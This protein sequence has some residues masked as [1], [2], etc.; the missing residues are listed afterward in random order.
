MAGP[1]ALPVHLWSHSFACPSLSPCPTSGELGAYRDISGDLGSSRRSAAR[2]RGRR[3]RR[4][5]W[6]A[7]CRRPVHSAARV[8]RRRSQLAVAWATLPP[9]HAPA[10]AAD[11]AAISCVRPSLSRRRMR[12]EREPAAGE[13][14]GFETVAP[15]K[16]TLGNKGRGGGR[17]QAW[18]RRRQTVASPPYLPISP[19]ISTL[20]AGKVAR[21]AAS[22]NTQRRPPV[23]SGKCE[24]AHSQRRGEAGRRSGGCPAPAQAPETTGPSPVH[25]ACVHSPS[26]AR[27]CEEARHRRT[28][29][30]RAADLHRRARDQPRSVTHQRRLSLIHQREGLQRRGELERWRLL[31]RRRV[32][33]AARSSRLRSGALLRRLRVEPYQP[34]PSLRLCSRTP[35]SSSAA[36]SAASTLAACGASSCDTTNSATSC[37]KPPEEFSTTVHH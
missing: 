9:T 10:S 29:R 12:A 19:H 27:C 8:K 18:E 15:R 20:N 6:R 1:I 13:W 23:H 7:Q 31:R 21:R 33:S 24:E 14:R 28:E 34:S 32:G 26:P 36:C 37:D 5:R 4:Q 2:R 30:H 3:E 22:S 11:G 35:S 17:L 16:S 25:S